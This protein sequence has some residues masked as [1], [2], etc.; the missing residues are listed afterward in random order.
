MGENWFGAKV[1]FQSAVDDERRILVVDDS[2]FIRNLLTPMLAAAGYQVTL[3]D[4]AEAA[5]RLREAGAH[6][7][8]IVSDIEMPG[9]DGFAFAEHVRRGG[10]WAET[11]LI[12]LTSHDTQRDIDRGRQAG[13][14]HHIGKLDK[15]ALLARLSMAVM[16]AGEAA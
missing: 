6:F 1:P 10:P 12:A 13:F 3:A 14:N 15:S 8:A 4:G 7:A 5:L 9:M 2:A 11:P 16:G